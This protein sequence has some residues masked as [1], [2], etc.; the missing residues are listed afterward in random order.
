MVFSVVDVIGVLTEQPDARGAS[1]YWAKMKQRLNEEGASEL[2]TN[3]QQLKLKATDGKR[4][5]TDVANTEQ[6]L[7]II[8]SVPSQKAEPLKRWLAEF[9]RERM[10]KI[11][12]PELIAERLAATYWCLLT[13]RKCYKTRNQPLRYAEVDLTIDELGS[14]IPVIPHWVVTRK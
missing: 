6:M 3:C 13:L 10:E 9:G 2:L 11:L 7:R 14:C 5:L 4:R 12:D 8:Q 1:N